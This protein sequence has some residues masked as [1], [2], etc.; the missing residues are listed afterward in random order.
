MRPEL[1]E[2][3]SDHMGFFVVWR[4]VTMVC[5]PWGGDSPRHSY[6]TLPIVYQLPP[7]VSGGQLLKGRD[8]EVEPVQ[9]TVAPNHRRVTRA[10][11]G[12]QQD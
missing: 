4:F 2:Q 1:S 11:R 5:L 7:G 9:F 10:I 12:L 3:G 6:G 8:S